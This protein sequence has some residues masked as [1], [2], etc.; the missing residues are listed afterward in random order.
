[1]SVRT[2]PRTGTLR[3]NGP[4]DHA[5]RFADRSRATRRRRW[6]RIGLAFLGIGLFAAAAWALGWSSLA[7][8]RTVEVVGTD[9]ATESLIVLSA[10]IEPGTPLARL[11][12]AAVADRVSAVPV[13]ADVSVR[14]VWPHTVRITITER[15]PV[16]VARRDSLWRL[17]DQTGYDFAGAQRGADQV[18]VLALDLAVAPPDHVA[19]GVAVIDGLPAAVSR[20]VARVLVASPDD[21]RLRLRSGERVWWGG[22]SDG[23]RKAEVLLALLPQRAARYDLRAPDAPTTRGSLS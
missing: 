20:R 17:V 8:V 6:R 23:A 14:R 19:A 4:L 7:G 2:S 10:D 22:A 12:T 18:P 21:V 5:P 16:A 13:V 1:M 11:D 15:T 3:V 9:R